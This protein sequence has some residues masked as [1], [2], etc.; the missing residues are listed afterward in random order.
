MRIVT[1]TAN[2]V[3]TGDL[4]ES[5]DGREHRVTRVTIVDSGRV[6]LSIECDIGVVAPAVVAYQQ[7][8]DGDTLV[9][10]T[11]ADAWR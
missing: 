5:H 2:Q 11:N 3:L 7:D 8:L 4:L 6:T 1:V 10:V 9:D